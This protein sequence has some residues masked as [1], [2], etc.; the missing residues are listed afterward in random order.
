MPMSPEMQTQVEASTSKSEKRQ[1][2]RRP[3]EAIREEMLSEGALLL[4]IELPPD[5]PQELSAQ[6]HV[7][8]S[9][10]IK[11]VKDTGCWIPYKQY[12]P[13]SGHK[14]IKTAYHCS[15]QLFNK[16]E[17]EDDGKETKDEYGYPTRKQ[18]SHLC[19]L[20]MCCNPSHL[21]LEPQW[22]NK[23]RNYCGRNAD[24]ASAGRCTCGKQ[25]PC[26]AMYRSSEIS[27]E[28]TL[29]TYQSRNV[30][31]RVKATCPELRIKL[32]P[33]NK[34]AKQDLQTKNR[35]KRK[36]RSHKHK[37]QTLN[38]IIKKQKRLDLV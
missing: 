28:V 8:V 20:W 10:G 14:R 37:Q 35:K 30:G 19:H 13:K 11:V 21:V 4:N 33:A 25:P 2:N 26:L 22:I 15:A 18:Y 27:R 29:L 31:E 7:I 23:S 24:G 3:E 1:R 17:K 6:W 32:F 16:L 36:K 38:N 5:A 12:F 34:Y 9:K